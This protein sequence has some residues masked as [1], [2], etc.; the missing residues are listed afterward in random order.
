MKQGKKMDARMPELRNKLLVLQGEMTAKDFADKL[1]LSR[2]T[3]GFYLSGQRIPDAKT[4]EQICKRCNV[5]SD[6]LLG[7]SEDR[8]LHPSAV[9]ELGL[10]EEAIRFFSELSRTENDELSETVRCVIGNKDFFGLLFKINA[11]ISAKKAEKILGT[12]REQEMDYFKTVAC[13]STM[14]FVL[15]IRRIILERT[16]EI[17]KSGKYS[18]AVSKAIAAELDMNRQQAS[19]EGLLHFFSI[20]DMPSLSDLA[21]YNVSNFFLEFLKKI[22]DEQLES[23]EL[24]EIH[25]ESILE[26]KGDHNGND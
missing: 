9:D 13:D 26:S 17:A 15:E 22:A 2:Q 23:I 5:S 8:S 7:L 18:E 16:L 4:I 25:I 3:V 11:F 24:P 19:T 14:G 12:I 6:W 10:P 1:G 21:E 20:F